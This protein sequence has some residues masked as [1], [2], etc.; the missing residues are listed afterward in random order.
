MEKSLEDYKYWLTLGRNV[1]FTA[2]LF[3]QLYALNIPIEELFSYPKA[4]LGSLGLSERCMRELI[5]AREKYTPEKVL[6]EL[7]GNE[8]E[9]IFIFENDFPQILLQIYDPPFILYKKGSADLNALCVGIVGSR[10]LTDYGV[11]ATEKLA[12]DLAASGITIVSGLAL[13]IDAIAHQATI[14]EGGI[15][16]AVLGCGLGRIYP[17]SNLGV[18][19]EI[20]AQGGAI[21]TEFPFDTIPAKY[22]FPARNRI[23]SGISQGLVVTEA[24]ESSGSLI[25]ALAAL[26]QNRE[27]FAVP[28]SIFNLNSRGTNNLIRNG[29]HVCTSAQDVLDEFGITCPEAVASIRKIAG[30]TP[31]ETIIIECLRAE[32]KHID[33]IIKETGLS[34]SVVGSTVTI[35]EISAKVKQLGGNVFR[36]NF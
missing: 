13:G 4:K 19:K 28:G 16:I 31:E 6:Q 23:I 30:N 14:N 11:R 7:R 17:S 26:N 10:R 5:V 34:Q 20:I 35:M 25:T 29:A 21:I 36:L 1:R 15:T 24:A 2:A 9:P 33:D 22:N 27:V 3:H 12:S 32:P 18:A 8:I